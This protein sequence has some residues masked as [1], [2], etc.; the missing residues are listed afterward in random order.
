MLRRV[1]DRIKVLPNAL[2]QLRKE[3]PEFQYPGTFG[4][5]GRYTYR[6]IETRKYGPQC[7]GFSPEV[8]KEHGQVADRGWLGSGITPVRAEGGLRTQPFGA[9]AAP[10]GVVHEFGSGQRRHEI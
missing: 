3:V 2:F 9:L 6:K 1:A 5:V 7:P 8:L 4:E 10:V